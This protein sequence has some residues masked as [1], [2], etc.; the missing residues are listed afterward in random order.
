MTM[1]TQESIVCTC[2][3]RGHLKLA[4]NDQPYSSLWMV[5]SLDGFE[6]RGL[7]VTSMKDHPKDVLAHIKPTCPQCGQTGTVT[8]A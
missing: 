7:T 8:Y 3:H 1:R 2:G 6:G 5:Y 4:E